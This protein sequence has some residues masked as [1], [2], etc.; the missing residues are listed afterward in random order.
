MNSF[1]L[2][3]CFSYIWFNILIF[4]PCMKKKKLMYWNYYFYLV[5][6][7]LSCSQ[8]E[9]QVMSVLASFLSCNN[10]GSCAGSLFTLKCSRS[11]FQ[12]SIAL[13]VDHLVRLFRMIGSSCYDW[14]LFLFLFG[15]F[16]LLLHFV[17]TGCL[18]VGFD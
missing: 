12:C 13:T 14:L 9:Q 6:S 7:M 2:M 8:I 10:V 5:L 3:H 16:W 1:F 18:L 17:W 15:M 11:W 4:F